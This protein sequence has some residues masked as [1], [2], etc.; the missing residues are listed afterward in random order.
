M[1]MTEGVLASKDCIV[2]YL[3]PIPYLGTG[4]HRYVFVLYKQDRGKVDL[5]K[6]SLQEHW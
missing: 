1:Q 6:H 2:P 5:S 3:Q 4:F